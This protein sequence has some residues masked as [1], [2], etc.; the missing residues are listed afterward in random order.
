MR[1][2]NDASLDP[3]QVRDKALGLRESVNSARLRMISQREQLAR[4]RA[5][6][7][8]LREL[9]A[10][11]AAPPAVSS[12]P[13]PLPVRA[14]APRPALAV[15]VPA[16]P[17]PA[18]VVKEAAA[19]SAPAA[20]S[21]RTD[22]GPFAR[23]AAPYAA[24]MAFAVAFELRPAPRPSGLPL[25]AADAAAP[26]PAPDAVRPAPAVLEDD[27]ADEALLLVHEW[28]LPGDERTVAERLDDGVQLPGA[29]P[30]WSAERTGER[31]YRVSYRP[32]AGE[33][34][35]DFDVDLD[36][37]RVDPTP[38]TAELIAPRLTARR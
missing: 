1:T 15:P 2:E 19:D 34:V 33:P 30:A 22:F 17:A 5:E 35:Y 23:R 7:T 3:R 24:I 29:E 38:D 26:K 13:S 6:V 37:R 21:F 8:V 25:S 36:A 31:V 12:V 4:L 18:P 32:P 11:G 20:A 9:A 14:D 16:L 10:L 28:R 27:G